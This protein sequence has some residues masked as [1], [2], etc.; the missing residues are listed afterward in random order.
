LTVF[1]A[2]IV[3]EQAILYGPCLLGTKVLLPLD[4][5]EA[6][7]IFTPVTPQ[8][9]QT[10]V[11]NILLSD[12]VYMFEPARRFAAAELQQGRLPV[13]APY[14]FAGVPVTWPKFSPFLFFESLTASP[15]IIAWG[16]LLAALV[17]G[18]GAY[19][20]FRQALEVSFWPAAIAAWCYPLTGFFVFWQ[21]YPT[22]LAVCWLPWELLAVHNVINGGGKGGRGIRTTETPEGGTGGPEAGCTSAGRVGPIWL[23]LATCL[24]LISGHL[25]VAGQVLLASGLYALWCLGEVVRQ[26]RR[27][28]LKLAASLAAGWTLGFLL[29]SPYVLPVLDYARQGARMERRGGGEEER[30]PVGPRALPLVVLPELYGSYG[31]MKTGSY[32][33]GPGNQIESAAAGY[34]GVVAALVL[35]PLAWC[36]RRR[37]AINT[38][39]AGMAFFG[40]T[41]CLN[42]PGFVQILRLPGLNMMSH[43]R[44]VFI[45]GFAML[46]LAATGLEALWR[47]E[48]GGGRWWYGPAGLL[49]LLCGWCLFR[50]FN[51]PEPLDTQLAAAVVHGNRAG[52]IHDLPDV[53]GAQ[54]WFVR[55]YVLAAAWCGAGAALWWLIRGGGKWR[56]GLGKLTL[57]PA[58]DELPSRGPLLVGL[59]GVLMLGDLLCFAWGKSPQSDPAGYFP[60]VPVLERLAKSDPGRVIGYNCLPANVASMAGLEDIRGYDS[61]DPARML[62]LLALGGDARSKPS[63]ALSQ[64]LAPKIVPAPDGGIRLLPVLNMLNVAYVIFR[65]APPPGI[66]P[67]LQ[68]P[69]YWVMRNEAAL[70]RVYVPK[71]VEIETQDPA[72]LAKIG[73][74]GFAPRQVAYVESPLR[75]PISCEGTAE[76]L[77]E[78]PARLAL[79]VHMKT[80][81]LVVVADSWDK[82]WR[83]WLNGRRVP[84]LRVNHAL[85]GVGVPQGDSTL[86]M[87]Y[88]PASFR[89]GVWF[90]AL[91]GAAMA[92]WWYMGRKTSSRHGSLP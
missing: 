18:L 44:L 56:I 19:M 92:A 72:R 66:R 75:M 21:G 76:V 68:G 40:L 63:Y 15:R 38:L 43:N 81:G 8:T 41:W 70:P 12:L 39:W 14:Q 34:A 89:L 29:A 10:L 49:V 54:A 22:S 90:A 35:A 57:P 20:F 1:M 67:L 83:A 24:V 27:D 51:L 60:T 71:T 23:G 62:D 84:I 64:K 73:S 91:A 30:P 7:A 78:T 50:T 11:Q 36:S 85:R 74:P 13:W 37:R 69:D 58:P 32:Y 42:V 26:A 4:I 17:A 59:A 46:A 86:E 53:R 5:L 16:Q 82:G 2:G 47:G 65:G 79:S 48:A 80:R 28:A 52:W 25:D 88:E 6:P 33:L 9:E 87:R 3:L 77:A 55:H 61:A 45:F 31:R